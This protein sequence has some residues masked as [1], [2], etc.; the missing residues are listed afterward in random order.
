[1]NNKQR[2]IERDAARF[3][4]ARGSPKIFKLMKK[5]LKGELMSTCFSGGPLDDD[6]A[7]ASSKHLQ[8]LLAAGVVTDNGQ[9]RLHT[10]DYQQRAYVSGT[11]LCP[12]ESFVCSFIDNMREL[13]LHFATV[14]VEPNGHIEHTL[15]GEEKGPSRI[16]ED[17]S[18][19][20]ITCTNDQ[21]FVTRTTEDGG[22]THVFVDVD[23]FRIRLISPDQYA[24]TFMVWESS[25]PKPGEVPPEPLELV[26]LRAIR[27]CSNESA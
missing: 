14:S 27:M 12:T 22:Q 23:P 11:L 10:P 1:M 5:F 18:W 8:A 16:E 9:Q 17:G 26:L 21:I 4:K 13:G 7:A 15:H 25:W 20:P 2:Q 3:M 19:C 24:V 6:H